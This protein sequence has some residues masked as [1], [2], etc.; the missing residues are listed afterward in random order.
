MR[1]RTRRR[2]ESQPERPRRALTIKEALGGYLARAGLKARLEQVDIIT[3][4]PELV[5]AQVAHATTPERMTRDGTLF[6]RV[7]SAAWL[8]EL[9]LMTPVV[10]ERLAQHTTAV[11]RIVWR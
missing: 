8:Q 3:R 1:D 11:K 5:G 7:A 9:Q 6:V 10:M 2:T 4:W